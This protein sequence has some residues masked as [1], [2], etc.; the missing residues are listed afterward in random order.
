[1]TATTTEERADQQLAA[2]RQTIHDHA[3]EAKDKTPDVIIGT[4]LRPAR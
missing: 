4:S 2:M 1:M 3:I